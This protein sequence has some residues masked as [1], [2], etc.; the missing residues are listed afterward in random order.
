M[1]CEVGRQQLDINPFKD[2]Y[3]PRE[4]EACSSAM[5]LMNLTTCSTVSV[6]DEQ[7]GNRFA[8]PWVRR[9]KPFFL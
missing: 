8:F 3:T 4:K 5:F 2:R 6:E 9:V 7:L 1:F